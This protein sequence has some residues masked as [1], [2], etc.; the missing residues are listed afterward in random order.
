M[1]ILIVEDEPDLARAVARSCRDEGWVADMVH[2]GEAALIVAHQ[3]SYDV[4]ILDLMLPRMDG[5]QVLDRLRQQ[6]LDVPVLLLTARDAVGDRV[7]GLDA[8]ADDYLTKPFA[9]A[10]L[11]ARLRALTR[12]ATVQTGSDVEIGAFRIDTRARR[13]HGADGEVDL[14]AREYAILALLARR[15]GEVVSRTEISDAIYAD[16]TEVFSNTIDVHIG[17]L[18]RKL[19]PGLIHTRRGQGYLLD[20]TVNDHGQPQ[21]ED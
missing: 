10:E 16:D 8:G 21:H 3:G 12:R 9:T 19:G 5:W 20:A 18:R 2:D 13:V 4:L 15:L 1:R 14:T 6:R 7:R 11:L 17:A